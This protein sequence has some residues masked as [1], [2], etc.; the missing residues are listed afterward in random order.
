MLH[1]SLRTAP[2]TLLAL[3]AI[4]L[5]C[6]RP[7]DKPRIGVMPKLIGIGYF[8]AA[9]KGAREAAR[10]T[11]VDLVYDGPAVDSAEE[12]VKMIDRWIAQGFDMIAV[13]PNDPELIAPALARARKVG[14]TV[15]TWDAD[16][17]PQASGRQAFINQAPIDAVGH[18]LVD[19]V[20][21]AVGGKG[22]VVI[23][24]GS[25]TSP[26]QNA[27]MKAMHARLAE[28][29]PDL[30]LLE[31]L[32]SDEDQAKAYRLARDVINAHPDLVG[33]WGIT[34]VALPG[35]A[36]AVRDA[37]KADKIAVTGVSLPS[38]MRQY[39]DD[40]TV[41]KFVLWS[42][43]DLGY[44]TVHAANLLRQ[45]KLADGE[46]TIGRLTNIQVSPGEVLLGPPIIF[47]RENIAQFDF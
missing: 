45:G 16:A 33:I 3:A 23:L 21:E 1:G 11:G 15:V 5:G 42:P 46:H 29:Y 27:W 40:G 44:L 22:K 19:I 20:G 28:K 30:E 12:Q 17:N 41:K 26:N 2:L 34:S 35:A 39:V 6:A 9:E 32:V 4:A 14:I 13:A 25:A 47:D 43:V 38:I 37:G 31:T 18:T 24:T 10:E 36:K 7:S 8:T